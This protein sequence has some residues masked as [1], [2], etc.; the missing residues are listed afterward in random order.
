MARGKS[1]AGGQV[2]ALLFLLV[3]IGGY[4]AWNY[5]RNLEAEAKVPRP[6]KGYSDEQLDQ[7]LAAYQGQVDA[8]N[9]RYEAVASRRTRSRDTALLGEAVDEFAR[10]QGRS[11]AVRELGAQ[12]SQEQASLEA[13]QAEK[14]LRVKLGGKLQTFLRR[15]FLPPA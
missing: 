14:A 11:R 7:L 2:M 6:Y 4:G 12:A 13:I 15:A 5:Q 1:G 3:L 9:E 10:V 8:L